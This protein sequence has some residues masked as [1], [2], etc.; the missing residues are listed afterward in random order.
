M[1]N[2]TQN[3]IFVSKNIS[4]YTPIKPNHK[5]NGYEKYPKII[6]ISTNANASIILPLF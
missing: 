5:I 2:I 1:A 3:K 4:E 6:S